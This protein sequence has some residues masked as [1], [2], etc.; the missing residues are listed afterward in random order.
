MQPLRAIHSIPLPSL[1]PEER[2]V[3]RPS[4]P[5]G[6]RLAPP[7]KLAFL[8]IPLPNDVLLQIF[9]RV[10]DKQKLPLVC[11]QW[12]EACF[13]ASYIIP[14]L[15]TRKELLPSQVKAILFHKK[16]LETNPTY[17]GE[18]LSLSVT[19]NKKDA[20]L[21]E[22]QDLLD[23][24]DEFPQ[25]DTLNI[26]IIELP[27]VVAI[28]HNIF[29]LT[30]DLRVL[31]INAANNHLKLITLP[32]TLFQVR[33]PGAFAKLASIDFKSI[34]FLTD[35][36]LHPLLERTI[37]LQK[38]TIRNCPL[39][40]SCFHLT[41]PLRKLECLSLRGLAEL[42]EED[43]QPL[44]VKT[45]TQLRDLEI[46]DCPLTGTSFKHIEAV[47]LPRLESLVLSGQD[48]G[49]REVELSDENLKIPLAKATNLRKLIIGDFAIT[50]SCFKLGDR[51]VALA[52]L[53]ELCLNHLD[54]LDFSDDEGISSLLNR[55]SRLKK[56]KIKLCGDRNN[57]NLP[58]PEFPKLIELTELN[59]CSLELRE[60]A[61]RP[62]LEDGEHLTKLK[63]VNYRPDNLYF[64]LNN[65]LALSK[66]T[67]LHCRGVEGPL[68]L[69]LKPILERAELLRDLCLTPFYTSDLNHSFEPWALT[70]SCFDLRNP[71][72]L[73]KLT[74]LTTLDSNLTDRGL[75]SIFEKATGLVKLH[76]G[77]S[78]VTVSCFNLIPPSALNQLREVLLR[79]SQG[80]DD[81]LWSLLE[82]APPLNS[83]YVSGLVPFFETKLENLE[84]P[85][86]TF[87]KQK[88]GGVCR[89]PFDLIMRIISCW[90]TVHI[91]VKVSLSSTPMPPWASTVSNKGKKIVNF[92]IPPNSQ[93]LSMEEQTERAKALIRK[94]D[95]ILTLL[96]PYFPSEMSQQDI[97]FLGK[98]ITNA[99]KIGASKLIEHI[100]KLQIKS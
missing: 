58:F 91:F 13:L 59:L 39:S 77:A 69:W 35:E 63:L 80:A 49:G 68:D 81:V 96:A 40:G 87:I 26:E 100:K 85:D 7:S 20:E 43:L 11:K 12:R 64:R 72:A 52:K 18:G 48:E 70:D 74:D 47:S 92:S 2:G 8:Q 50:G 37:A 97:D 84:R 95:K 17:K 55:T 45:A 90:V 79:L 41:N 83:L 67:Y 82:R 60:G 30:T 98:G 93:P 65:P 5:G 22:M 57:L 3:Q 27:E 29:Q 19:I 25:I 31:S 99:T 21:E 16:F 6:E 28:L 62:V 75:Q 23:I 76:L 15:A 36:V 1:K 33:N 51:S 86:I 42:K 54:N 9:L 73:K 44:L 61:L 94:Y 24:V 71:L 4:S 56:L 46:F 34:G 32:L 78:A 53:E 88:R 66:L 10:T 38:L 14:L 89:A